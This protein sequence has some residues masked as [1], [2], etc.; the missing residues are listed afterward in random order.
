MIIIISGYTLARNSAIANP[1]QREWVP[2][3]LCENTSL[4]LPKESVSYLRDSV[5]IWYVIA[6]WWWS[7]QTMFTSVSHVVPGYVS[8]LMM[9]SAQMRIRQSFVVICHCVT[10]AFLTLFLLVQKVG[11]TLSA[12]CRIPFS[13]GS[14]WP[15]LYNLIYLFWR[16]RVNLFSPLGVVN[17][18]QDHMSN[19][20][21]PTISSTMSVFIWVLVC[22]YMWSTI[23][24]GI[25]FWYF[26][27][28]YRDL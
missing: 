19:K 16:M 24:D 14:S 28:V 10:V 18:S 2:T 26:V 15:F 3:S 11:D 17:Y 21:A 20:N 23:L 12:R 4:S 1:D 25:Y 22:L 6:V 27:V 13:C 9:I 5:V 8:S 7:T